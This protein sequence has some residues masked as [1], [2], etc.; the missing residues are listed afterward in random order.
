MITFRKINSQ[1]PQVTIRQSIG[2]KGAVKLKIRS[3]IGDKAVKL[4]KVYTGTEHRE[5]LLIQ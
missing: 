3:N 1:V 4:S 2:H 5:C